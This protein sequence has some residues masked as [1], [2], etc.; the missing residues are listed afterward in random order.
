MAE[1]RA[2]IGGRHL[3]FRDWRRRS[4]EDR[5]RYAA[6]KLRLAGRAWEDMNQCADAK[7]AVIA[8]INERAEAWAAATDGET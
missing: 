8:E 2:L 3:L 1:D 6:V 5:A 4:P 7:S